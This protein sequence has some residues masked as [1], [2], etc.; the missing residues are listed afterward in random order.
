MAAKA[1]AMTIA[2]RVAVNIRSVSRRLPAAMLSR[3]GRVM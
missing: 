3:I 1:L 2:M